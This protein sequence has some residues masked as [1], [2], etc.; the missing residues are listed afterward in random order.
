MR[1]FQKLQ[2]K[3]F[4]YF[5]IVVLIPLLSLGIF[6]YF[7]STG[8]LEKQVLV[9]QNQTIGLIQSNIKL[10]LDDV[11]DISSYIM[12]NETFQNLLNQSKPDEYNRAQQTMLSYL[13]NLKVAK[14]YISFIIVY[15][16]NGFLFRDFNE[17]YREVIPYL[18]L[19]E[20]PTYIG[21]AAKSGEANWMFSS[22]PLFPYLQQYNEIM[23]GRRITN[24]YD[25][26][27]KLG[28]LFM[29]I[30]RDALLNSI[31][32][33][34]LSES[35][36]LLLIDDNYNLVASNQRSRDIQYYR[37]GDLA[38]KKKLVGPEADPVINVNDRNYYVSTAQ[39]KPYGWSVVSLTPLKEIRSQHQILL[40]FT[41]IASISLL[42]IVGLLSVFLSRNV[43]SPI[44]KLLRSMSDFKRG[45]FNQKVPVESKDEIGLLT[46]KYNQ[47]VVELNELIQKVY[48]SQTNQKMI[49]LKTLQAQI[50]P[51][52]LYNTL[53]YIFLNS[54]IN[55]DN[56]TAEVVRSLSQLF[57]ISLNRGNDYYKLENEINQVR[58]YVHIQ[59]A[60][61]P[62]R[63]RVEY[64][65][66]PAVEPYLT[67]KLLLQPIVENAII[68]AFDAN[69][70]R[71][72]VLR[73][74]GRMATGSILFTVEDNGKGMTEQQVAALLEV[75]SNSSG[76]YGIKNVNERLTMLF[77]E[78]YRLRIASTID[79]G[80]TVTICLPM[81]HNEE[82]W[83]SLYESHSHR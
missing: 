4:L 21:T 51:H 40:R 67:S 55:G 66:N 83:V 16:E 2:T 58:A 35:T 10:M 36:Q 23:I 25:S 31:Q 43:T 47:M 79:K 32:D 50:E 24:I 27:Q 29:G 71:E 17:F 5:I 37:D 56:D 76:G 11:Q 78:E 70:G 1:L 42:L 12:N 81:I 68:H 64:D 20:T 75:S 61:F 26:D 7:T 39:V 14:S 65:I 72:G 48:I 80:T 3:I 73:I 41:L 44:R 8:L 62:Q 52:F 19:F 82:E 18:Q 15:G 60:R 77:G 57:R 28:M 22:D 13:S 74:T 54:K 9:N 59:H 49:E 45:D 53:D 34:E 6:S 30:R 38:F 46:Q 69:M 63:F 33:I